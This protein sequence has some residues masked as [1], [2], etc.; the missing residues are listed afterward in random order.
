MAIYFT[1]A[2]G[3]ANSPHFINF[4]VR[5]CSANSLIYPRIYTLI[6]TSYNRE[7]QEFIVPSKHRGIA[8]LQLIK[9]CGQISTNNTIFVLFILTWNVGYMVSCKIFIYPTIQLVSNPGIAQGAGAPSLWVAMLTFLS[10]KVVTGL[11]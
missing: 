11:L 3:S 1:S 10:T 6:K 2:D 9:L 5:A 4:S 7:T 8:L